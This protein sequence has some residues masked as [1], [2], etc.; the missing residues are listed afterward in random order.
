MRESVTHYH[1]MGSFA[2]PIRPVRLETLIEKRDLDIEGSR[3]R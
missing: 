3:R 1:G 2:V